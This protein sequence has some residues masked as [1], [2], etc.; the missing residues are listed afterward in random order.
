MKV[1][2]K[3][4]KILMPHCGICKEMFGGNNSIA[5]PYQCKCGTWKNSW[6]DPIE[7]ELVKKKGR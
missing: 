1:V 5:S 6:E 7:F 2:Y 4:V 3:R